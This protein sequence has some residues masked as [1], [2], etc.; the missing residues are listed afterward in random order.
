MYTFNCSK[1]ISELITKLSRAK[2]LNAHWSRQRAFCLNFLFTQGEITH[3]DWLSGKMLA[4][5]WVN[6]P[7]LHLVNFVILCPTTTSLMALI[8][9]HESPVAQK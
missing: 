6:L 5:D 9:S 3:S 4:P 1:T 8:S 7:F 2:L